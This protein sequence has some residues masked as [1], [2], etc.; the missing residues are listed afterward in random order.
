MNTAND[1]VNSWIN[2]AKNSSYSKITRKQFLKKSYQSI[3][4]SKIDT[5]QVSNL[6]VIAYQSLK[7]G[8]TLLFKKQ[9]KE[10]LSIAKKFNDSFA[11]GDVHWNYASYYNKKQVY[12]SAF[13]HFNLAHTYFDKSGHLYESAKTQYGMAFTKGRFKDYS[14]SE[15]LTFKAI[16]KF[17]TLENYKS[18]ASCYDHLGQLQNDI[19]EYDRALLYYNKAIEYSNK[20]AG[21]HYLKE[22]ILNNIGIALLR[23]KEYAKAASYFSKVLENENIKSQNISHYARVLSNKAYG[24][25]LMRDTIDIAQYLKEAL[26]IR[27]SLN[28][29]G[30]III[31][32]IHLAHYYVYKQDTAAAISLVKEANSLA[33]KIKNSRDYLETLSLLAQLDIKNAV[34]HLKKHI[35]FSDSLQTVERKIQNKFMRISYET[36]EYIE[37]TERLSQKIIWVLLTSFG[38]ILTLGLLYFIKIQNAKTEKLLLENEQQKANEQVYLITLKQQEELEKEKIGE[39]NRIAEELHDG[40]LSKLFGTRVGLG[41]LDFECDENIR[42][43][44]QLFLEELQIIEKEIREV[45]HQLSNNIDSSQIGFSKIIYNLIES[46]CKIGNFKYELDFDEHINWQKI[47]EV[48]K[49]NLYRII[50]EALLNIIKYASA[51][52]LTVSFKYNNRNLVII[53]KDDGLGFDAKQKKKGIG[54]KNMKSRVKKIN[55]VFYLHSKLNEGTTIKIQVPI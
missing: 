53:I 15:V 9:N 14:G 16:N 24:N 26:H 29:K 12:D 18:L 49:V 32:K 23:K 42:K 3:K 1:S 25:L 5:S 39:R 33:E 46:K 2:A 47:N 22:A 35:Q 44:H 19:Y 11:L 37:E 36:D 27:D 43:Q 38:L 28:D 7:L 55:G 31:S 45:S 13:Y 52:N 20:V 17:E 30:G 34:E 41:F 40:I 51:K 6:S 48:I 50:Q 54:I 21:N 10:A 8:D 4:S